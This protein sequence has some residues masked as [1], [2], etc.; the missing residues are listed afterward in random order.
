MTNCHDIQPLADD[1]L[2][3]SLTASQRTELEAHLA[4]CDACRAFFRRC[5]RLAMQLVAL[6]DAANVV[7]ETGAA[8]RTLPLWRRA[9]P[10]RIAAAIA[11]VATAGWLATRVGTPPRFAPS[12]M[13]SELPRESLGTASEVRIAMLGKAEYLQ[14]RLPSADPHVH[15]VWLYE[16]MVLAAEPASNEAGSGPPTLN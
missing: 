8:P 10:W 2:D 6:G 16:P 1:W 12:N 9:A 14:V 15:I 4:R 7:A 13:N 3:D 5:E 11:L